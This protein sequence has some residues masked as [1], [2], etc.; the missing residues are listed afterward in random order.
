MQSLETLF[1]QLHG[2]WSNFGLCKEI[3]FPVFVPRGIIAECLFYF[4][5]EGLAPKF[6]NY[7]LPISAVTQST[8]LESLVTQLEKLT[9]SYFAKMPCQVSILEV[10]MSLCLFTV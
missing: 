6:A 8:Q 9:S 3:E 1:A 10:S 4:P 7:H 5:I 2:P